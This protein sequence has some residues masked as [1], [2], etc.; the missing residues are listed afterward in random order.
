M[1]PAERLKSTFEQVL[2][3]VR[4]RRPTP[5]SFQDGARLNHLLEA[6][7]SSATSGGAVVVNV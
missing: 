7:Y 3:A 5:M 1:S 2:A 6:A 4:E